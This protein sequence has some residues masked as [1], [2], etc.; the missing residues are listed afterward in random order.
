M[1]TTEQY[2]KMC[3]KAVEVQKDRSFIYGDL[4]S[5][6]GCRVLL[7]TRRHF[8]VANCIWLPRQD[9]LQAMMGDTID[10]DRNVSFALIVDFYDWVQRADYMAGEQEW[11]HWSMEQ[12]WLAF[13]MF[14]LYHKKVWDG[15]NWVK[16]S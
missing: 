16:E 12:L 3:T 13:V 4:W 1:D 11:H 9:Q 15:E 2:V 14:T 5:D 6:D 7:V 8:P 10:A